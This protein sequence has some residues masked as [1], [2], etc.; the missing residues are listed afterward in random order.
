VDELEE[1]ADGGG[2]FRDA[3]DEA[4]ERIST[5]TALRLIGELPAAQAEMVMLRVVI[6]L[7]VADVAEIVGKRPG[8]VRVAVHRALRTLEARLSRPAA[9]M[10]VTHQPA[11]TFSE[12]D[13]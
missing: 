4:E 7:D 6:G 12:H 1:L 3:A 5:A 9:A 13:A 10:D 2:A 11:S 8:A